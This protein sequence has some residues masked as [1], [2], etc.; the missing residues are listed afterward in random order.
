MKNVCIYDSTLAYST[1]N[2]ICFHLHFY[3]VCYYL[4]PCPFC[5]LRPSVHISHVVHLIH[6]DFIFLLSM[7]I[8]YD[9]KMYL[10]EFFYKSHPIYS[11]FTFVHSFNITR[12]SRSILS[13]WSVSWMEHISLLH[14]NPKEVSQKR[15]C[16]EAVSLTF[17]E[18][19]MGQNSSTFF[20]PY[21]SLISSFREFVCLF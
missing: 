15:I 16:V 5:F 19:R 12:R 13:T 1:N 17:M 7:V 10:F 20:M 9:K 14:R 8:W 3:E 21:I 6:H 18:M 2:F 4:N 11:P